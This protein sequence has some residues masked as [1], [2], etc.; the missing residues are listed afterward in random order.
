[1]TTLEAH[2]I[3]ASYGGDPVL[4]GISLRIE[5]GRRVAIVGPNGSGKST[6]LR[7]MASLMRPTSGRVTLDG[8]NVRAIPPRERAQ[9]IACLPQSPQAPPG[10][11]VREL[12]AMGRSP[13]LGVWG[14]LAEHDRTI[15]DESIAMCDLGSLADRPLTDLS[16]G[17]RQRA[18]IAMAL[19]QRPKILLLDEPTAALDIHHQLEV[20]D[21]LHAL[22]GELDMGI[23]VVL[24]E[25]DL[26]SR[27]AERVVVLSDGRV[28]ADDAPGE[29]L[30]AG[31]I[32]RVFRVSVARVPAGVAGRE[33][34]VFDRLDRNR[35]DGC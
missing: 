27:F 6:L 24:H 3:T 22:A 30:S 31:V 16:G 7:T 11:S 5:R 25:L 12:V 21:R 29:A 18:W 4:H 34:L 13:A 15:I 26:A 28:A 19:A 14:R 35:A 10:T 9:Q 17:E 2:D 8:R 20:I 33:A 32:R 1:M 23:V